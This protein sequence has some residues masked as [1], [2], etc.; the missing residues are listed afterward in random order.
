MDEHETTF[1][2]P[3]TR[4][5]PSNTRRLCKHSCRTSGV[6]D[7]LDD[8]NYSLCGSGSCRM[9]RLVVGSRSLPSGFKGVFIV[10]CQYVVWN[11]SV[12][13]CDS[14]RD[15][16]IGWNYWAPRFWMASALIMG[17]D[18]GLK[19]RHLIQVQKELIAKQAAAGG[20]GAGY[21]VLVHHS[22]EEGQGGND[23]AA[24]PA[25]P[26]R[27]G[28]QTRKVSGAPALF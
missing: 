4:W 10:G 16:C 25:H 26:L 20:V 22:G 24:Q 3:G 2:R 6:A 18:T 27:E 28:R 13:D 19:L 7:K 17:G 15:L 14:R 8:S 21:R 11:H 9:A 23:I 1:D 12:V 5:K